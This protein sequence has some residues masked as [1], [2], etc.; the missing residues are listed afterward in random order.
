ME[1]LL[2][3]VSKRHKLTL[4]LKIFSYFVSIFTVCVFLYILLGLVLGSIIV[5]VKYLAVLGIPFALVSML[6]RFIGAPRPYEIYDFYD[7][8]PKKSEKNSFPSRHAFSVFA[9]GTLTLFIF[10][11]LGSILLILGLAMCVA[12]VALGYHFPRDV[13]AGMVIGVLSSLIGLLFLK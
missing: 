6:R 11:I 9:I 2:Q 10:P 1:K 8:N 7:V 4:G 12:R 5:A 3:F 13:I